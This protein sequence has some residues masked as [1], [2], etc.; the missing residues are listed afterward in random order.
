MRDTQH[1]DRVISGKFM[2]FYNYMNIHSNV[3]H[4]EVLKQFKENIAIALTAK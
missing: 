3:I 2:W 4:T 1:D